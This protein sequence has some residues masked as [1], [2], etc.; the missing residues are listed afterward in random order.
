MTDKEFY[1]F[2]ENIFTVVKSEGN[3]ILGV[4]IRRVRRLYRILESDQYVPKKPFVRSCLEWAQRSWW[5]LAF[6]T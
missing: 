2:L 4:W 5:L 6:F 3:D 1:I